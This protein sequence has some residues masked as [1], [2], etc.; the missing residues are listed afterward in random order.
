MKKEKQV[1]WR[2]LTKIDHGQQPMRMHTIVIRWIGSNEWSNQMNRDHTIVIE[3][4]RDQAWVVWL[5]PAAP[6]VS[7]W[8]GHAEL[9]PSGTVVGW[10][11][12]V[13]WPVTFTFDAICMMLTRTN[14]CMRTFVAVIRAFVL[15]PTTTSHRRL[16]KTQTFITTF[17]KGIWKLRRGY[18][19]ICYNVNNEA[20]HELPTLTFQWCSCNMEHYVGLSGQYKELS[21]FPLFFWA[22]STDVAQAQNVWQRCSLTLTS[23]ARWRQN[24][25][26]A[27]A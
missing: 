26:F 17:K 6:L 10:L 24:S 27:P 25:K 20:M 4:I 23:R 16:S 11:A 8:L 14:V 19:G 18:F 3:W 2:E 15:V 5:Q 9:C 22:V 13:L 7:L 1:C 21:N 12:H